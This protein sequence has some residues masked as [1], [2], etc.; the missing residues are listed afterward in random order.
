MFYPG[1]GAACEVG[2][3]DGKGYTVN[4]PWNG[5]ACD[6]DY[7]TAFSQ[8]L[9]PIAYEYRPDLILVS[10]GFDAAKGD[11]IGGCTVTPACFAHMTSLLKAIAPL[12][13]MLEGGYNLSATARSTEACLRVLLGEQP[14]PLQWQSSSTN[15]AKDVVLE[16]QRHHAAFWKSLPNQPCGYPHPHP[17]DIVAAFDGKSP[18]GLADALL[19]TVAGG[20]W[21][22]ESGEAL[23]KPPGAPAAHSAAGACDGGE[24]ADRRAAASGSESGS[25]E[26]R[27]VRVA[28][29]A[30]AAGAGHKGARHRP[31]KRPLHHARKMQILRAVH[32]SAVRAFRR[33]CNR[34][35]RA[36]GG[37]VGL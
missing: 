4:V 19:P 15:M 16:V 35:T 14:Q 30:H 5:S 33:R 17:R 31:L 22:D 12:V 2:V 8:V 29:A 6:A 3:G 28:A 32:N 34:G 37:K 11:P 10:A 18:K 25:G 20:G 1:T 27:V 36:P 26:E 21:G 24:R 23:G 13:V 7:I 9:L